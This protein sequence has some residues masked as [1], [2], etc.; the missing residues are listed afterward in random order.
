MKQVFCKKCGGLKRLIVNGKEI[1]PEKWIQYGMA[2]D[3]GCI[4]ENLLLKPI[5]KN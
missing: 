2:L 3:I 1:P 5:S 4:C